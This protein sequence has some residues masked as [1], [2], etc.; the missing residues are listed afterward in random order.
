[1]E[2]SFEPWKWE[3]GIP[4]RPITFILVFDIHRNPKRLGLQ[5]HRCN[6]CSC[7]AVSAQS[8]VSGRCVRRVNEQRR[9]L[10]CCGATLHS[11]SRTA[12]TS[13]PIQKQ[14]SRF[15]NG[16]CNDHPNTSASAVQSAGSYRLVGVAILSSDESIDRSV[17]ISFL[18]AAEYSSRISI[19]SR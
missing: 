7:S 19:N 8:V 13:R 15:R 5:L 11:Y 10:P 18:T 16:R 3:N 4:L 6:G 17:S 12:N 1:V 2:E 14:H 9:F